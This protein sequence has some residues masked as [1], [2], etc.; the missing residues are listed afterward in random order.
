[1]F[2]Y[3]FVMPITRWAAN[4]YDNSTYEFYLAAKLFSLGVIG[5]RHLCAAFN[6]GGSTVNR[7][8]VGPLSAGE[9]NTLVHIH[10]FSVVL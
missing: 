6:T 2:Y 4:I 8:G 9:R 3:G 7:I 5:S 1:M 10:M